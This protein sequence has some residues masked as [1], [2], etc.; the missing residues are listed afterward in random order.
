MQPQTRLHVKSVVCLLTLFDNMP[1]K[2]K[3]M[4]SGVRVCER[5]T[6]ASRDVVLPLHRTM[7]EDV[8]RTRYLEINIFK[9]GINHPALS[10]RDGRFVLWEANV[11]RPK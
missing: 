11:A 10:D 9:D 4:L 2:E 7:F 8:L 3:G 5:F 1:R 6:H